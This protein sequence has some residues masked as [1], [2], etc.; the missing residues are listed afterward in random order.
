MDQRT[1]TK[2]ALESNSVNSTFIGYKN[3]YI[4]NNNNKQI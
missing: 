2:D 4:D 1:S 3:D